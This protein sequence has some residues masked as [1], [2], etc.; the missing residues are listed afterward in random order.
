MRHAGKFEQAH[1][2]ALFLDEIGD[3][4]LAMQADLLRV[5]E[6]GQVERVGGD[7]PLT[8][9]VRAVVATHRDLEELV[10][11]GGFRQDPLSPH[12]RLSA[13]AAAIARARR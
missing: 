2:G 4:P 5:L 9:D 11:Q 1:R 6:E 3:M 10:R 8:V 12:L 7:H 13:A